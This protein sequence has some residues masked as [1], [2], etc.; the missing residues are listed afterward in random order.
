MAGRNKRA[1]ERLDSGEDRTDSVV[2]RNGKFVLLSTSGEEL[3]VFETREAALLAQKNE[4]KPKRKDAREARYDVFRLDVGKAEKTSTGGL[5][6]PAYVTRAGVF[7]YRNSDGTER[8]EYRPPS[9][10]FHTDSLKS[11]EDVPVTDLH[12]GMVKAE[13]YQSLAKGH[14]RDARRDGD[15]VAMTALLQDA[16]LV[17]AVERGD[18]REFSMGYECDLDCTPGTT[19]EGEHY[20]AIQENIRYNHGAMLPIGSGRAGKAVALRLD[21]ASFACHYTSVKIRFDGKEY[22]LSVPTE[23]AAFE[24]AVAAQEKSREDAAKKSR[25]DAD[26]SSAKLQADLD[27]ANKDLTQA[28]ADLADARDPKKVQ[29]RVDARKALEGQASDILGKDAKFD[30]LTDEQI[31]EKC[32]LHSDEKAKARLDSLKDGAREVYLQA[33]FDALE[34]GPRED[35]AGARGAIVASQNSSTTV[36]AVE[37]P[38]M[39]NAWRQPLS[40]SKDRK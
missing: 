31:K 3:G 11:I 24:A 1:V 8:R 28:R 2:T 16:S 37:Q 35:S 19:P 4:Q 21:G 39:L 9:E 13:N 25:E 17:G 12:Q 23:K 30:G 18:R 20:D 5:R 15:F 26:A 27:K 40:Q 14:L 7:L 22:D 38:P 32:V 34:A 6:V 33:R 29:E 10:V 36:S